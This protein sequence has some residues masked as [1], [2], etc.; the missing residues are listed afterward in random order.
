METPPAGR[1]GSNAVV[2]GFDV[3]LVPPDAEFF[4]EPDAV[5][6]EPF[7]VA[8]FDAWSLAEADESLL[9]LL[10]DEVLLLGGADVVADSL[11]LLVFIVS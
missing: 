1:R 5:A 8:E 11:E 2:F 9:S 7:P 4:P 3:V 6:D 10:S